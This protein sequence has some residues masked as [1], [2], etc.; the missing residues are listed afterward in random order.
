MTAVVFITLFLTLSG[1]LPRWEIQLDVVPS[2]GPQLV[3][4]GAGRQCILMPLGNAGLGGW[5]DGG[6]V[7]PGF[8]LSAG[9][10]V[11]WRPAAGTHNGT[12]MIAYADNAGAAHFV[13]LGGRE[14]QGWP[15][16]TG[17]SIV[18][19][20]SIV[21]LNCDSSVEV[22]FG[23]SDGRVW[24]VGANGQPVH[25]W[26][27][28]LSSQLL[29]QPTQASLGGVAGRGLVCALSNS[30]LTVLDAGGSPLPGWPLE[31]PLPVGSNPVSGDLNSNG[32]TDIVFACQNR[33]FNLFSVNGRQQDGWPYFLSARP[34]SGS[35]A[36]GMIDAAASSPQTAL[37]TIDSLVYLVNGDGSLAESWR[38]PVRTGATAYQP[39]VVGTQSGTAVLAATEDGMIHAWNSRGE[40]LDGFP[41]SNPGGAACSPV[42]GDIDGD[43][44]G[45]LVILG[46]GGSLAVYSL[47]YP[48]SAAGLWL[49]PLSDASNTGAYGSSNVHVTTIGEIPATVSGDVAVPFCVNPPNFSG[50][51]LF[52]SLDAGYSWVETRNFTRNA[53]VIVWH[54]DRDLP[55]GNER[56]VAVRVTPLF[57]A[58]AGESG[59]SRIFHV[60]NN[61]PPTVSLVTP[62]LDPKGVFTFTYSVDDP[63][64]DIIQLQAQYST[65]GGST[66]QTAHLSGTTLEISPWFYGDPFHWDSGEDLGQVEVSGLHFRVRASD[67][68][69]GPWHT[70]EGLSV[71]NREVPRDDPTVPADKTNRPPTGQAP[72]RS[73]KTIASQGSGL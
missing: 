64:E 31:L 36:M 30:V 40:S 62:A 41:F 65:D 73:G 10:G 22:A 2:E 49:M 1:I 66:W 39:I 54:T 29:W 52:Y 50:I 19:G 37:S 24:L 60:D 12:T 11:L 18:T 9:A 71:D 34:V 72:T 26:P 58:G 4:D 15:V 5:S 44:L 28:D 32:E 25:G 8:P 55:H 56:Q 47:G 7:L 53:A 51:N 21:D 33:R 63:E 43:G 69:Q 42:A 46:R 14:A 59:I 23:T 57:N 68:K 17:S 38:W 48:Q 35:A 3:P 70:L 16:N 27:V 61:I 67:S 20:V 45:D 13:D 6:A